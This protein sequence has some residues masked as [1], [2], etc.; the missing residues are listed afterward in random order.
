MPHYP[1]TSPLSGV[2]AKVPPG[3]DEFPLE[4]FAVEIEAILGRWGNT[5]EKN[6][7]GYEAA[8]E[9][10]SDLIEASDPA[11]WKETVIRSGFGVDTSRRVFSSIKRISRDEMVRSLDK[12]IGSA[13]A[14]ETTEFEIFSIEQTNAT[15]VTVRVEVRYNLVSRV[16]KNKRQERVGTWKMEWFHDASDH[17]KARMW[18]F[19]GEVVCAVEN[20]AFVDITSETFGAIPSYESQLSRGADHWRTVLD[21]AT[22]ID[23]Y[24]NNGIAAGDFDGDG[25]DDLYICQP[26]GLPNRLYRNRGDGIFEDVTEK[27]GVGVLDGSA[28]ALFADFL[29]RGRQD[30]LVV[31]GTGPLLFLNNGDGTFSL[32]HD[33]FKFARPPQGSFT[34]AAIADYDNDGHLDV[35]FC[36]YM[37][38]VGLEQYNYPV[39]YY[40]A[41]NGPPNCL[42]RNQGDGTFIEVTQSSGLNINNDRYS[43]ACTWGDSNGNGL[44]DLFVANDFGS[45][46]LYRNNGDGTF[47]DVSQEA[48]IQSVGA[49]M[50]CCWSDYDNDGGQ[51]IY[52]PSM[53]EAAGQRISEQ[54]QFHSDA[55]DSIRELYRRHA[56]G[57]ALYHNRGG[58][59][60]NVGHSAGVEMGR[61]AWSSDFW[62]WDHDGFSDLYV[63]NGYLT[64]PQDDELAGFFWRQVVAKSPE[65]TTPLTAYE[66][67]WNAINE[68]IRSDHTWHGHARNVA[69][70]NNQDGTFSEASGALLMDFREDSR[71]FALADFDHD[72][73]LEVVLKNRNAP[74]IRVLHNAL[75]R[76]GAVISF[77]LRGTR[78]NRDAIGASI[79]VTAGKLVQTKYLQAGSGFLSQHSK[80][81][82]FG[83]ASHEGTVQASIRWPSGLVQT[84][85]QLPVFNRIRIEEGTGTFHAEPFSPYR[86]P[87]A[88]VSSAA[89]ET[90]PRVC[91]TWL[92]Q[93]LKAPAFTL[94][95]LDGTARSL[96]SWRGNPLVLTFWA[97]TSQESLR[98]I[99]FLNAHAADLKRK[100][101]KVLALNLDEA[102]QRATAS[103]IASQ[104]DPSTTVLFA[105]DEAAGIYNL[106]YRHLFDRQRDLPVPLSLLLDANGMIVKVY[107]GFSESFPFLEDST[108]IPRNQQERMHRALPFP[109]LLVQDSFERNDFTY[110]VALYQHGYLDQAAESFEQVIAAKP[111]DAN[112]YYNLGTLN[113]RRNRPDEAKTF[114][115]KTVELRPGFAEAW[116]NLGMI[117]AQQGQAEEAIQYFHKSIEIQPGYYT[118]HMNLGN[119]YRR[120]RAF[121]KARDFLNRALS[122][123]PDDADVQYSIGM[124]F[125]QQGELDQAAQHLQRAIALRPGYPEALNNLGVIHVRQNDATGAEDLFKTAIAVAPSF[126]QS[127]LN[128]ARLY[129]SR[130]ERQKAR[131]ILEQLLKLQPNNANAR[132]GLAV[133]QSAP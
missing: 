132:D 94:A 22:G 111:S 91:E 81:L 52:V 96:E 107:Q 4:K 105:T 34:H 79:K 73:R 40:D 80:E 117:A 82:F 65:D 63:T 67:G 116:N 48:H 78:S 131:D 92:I 102:E 62:D 112:A 97:T 5:L 123:R 11:L 98:Q 6:T 28:C 42:F 46:Q 27:A 83:L 76:I 115:Q 3:S 54:P 37:Y 109:G 41:K 126:D 84:F 125:A 103:K 72:G 93:P 26:A 100:S 16:E 19:G 9:I 69:F 127:Y 1:V 56:R 15:P 71:A 50:G 75:P 128:L 95:G 10:L 38:Y 64:S 53:W 101:L 110:G 99:E 74:Q 129:A 58:Q 66:N 133:L 29:N 60:E 61:W 130:N 55:P 33:A 8:S 49:G 30:L 86:A 12:W 21:G 120:Q 18:Q 122:L 36:L 20:P 23:I 114:L 119:L 77:C 70:S 43:F 68:L 2:L 7:K 51:E 44:L 85:E 13:L 88:R 57:N 45:S 90:L 25:L 118:A 39:P 106:L 108:S 14:I 17:W 35:Y 124:L 31:C 32:K 121:D 104:Y 47:K 89:R 113:L 87:E 59:F 24:G